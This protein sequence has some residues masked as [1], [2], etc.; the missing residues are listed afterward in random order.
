MMKS[1]NSI[2]TALGIA[3]VIVLAGAFWILLLNPKQEKADELGEQTTHLKAEVAAEQQQVDAGLTAKSNFPA[4][5]RQLVVLGKAVPAEAATPSLLV[6]LNGISSDAHT[7]FESIS[8]GGVGGE[9]ATEGAEGA[10]PIGAGAGPSGLSSMSYALKFDGGFF[11]IADFIHGLNGLVETHDGA[12]DANGRLITIDGFTLGPTE[13]EGHES[14]ELSGTFQVSTYVTPPGQGL[15]AGATL[16][17]P[18]GS[19]E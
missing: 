9:E 14:G 13:E 16:A 3:L 1:T 17:G 15:T 6:Q 4:Y 7:A 19:V 18:E 2:K 12:V 8:L 10:L 11:Q 5:Y